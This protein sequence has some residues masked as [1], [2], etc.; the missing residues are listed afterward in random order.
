MAI[1]NKVRNIAVIGLASLAIGACG[2]A[3]AFKPVEVVEESYELFAE[4]YNSQNAPDT[5]PDMDAITGDVIDLQIIPDVTEKQSAEDVVLDEGYSCNEITGSDVIELAASSADS[6][7]ISDT[8]DKSNDG[9]W[10]NYYGRLL[11]GT[12]EN[13]G[14]ADSPLKVPLSCLDPGAKYIVTIELANDAQGN[15]FYVRIGDSGNYQRLGE[16]YNAWKPIE[17][18]TVT[19]VAETSVQFYFEGKPSS[20]IRMAVRN[21]S[22]VKD[23]TP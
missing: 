4:R 20:T 19:G 12:N 3:D 5:D 1:K 22:A 15:N 11:G 16:K 14:T 23:Y 18:G 7:L 13:I 10:Y 17:I 9:R 2:V 6:G 8:V 21:I